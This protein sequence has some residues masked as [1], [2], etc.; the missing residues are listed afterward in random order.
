MDIYLYYK[1]ME[2]DR[3][4]EENYISYLPFTLCAQVVQE[5]T[6]TFKVF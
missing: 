1:V 6:S 2:D 3:I 4:N 5:S